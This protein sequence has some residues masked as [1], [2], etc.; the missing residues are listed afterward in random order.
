MS[1]WAE[2]SSVV[3]DASWVSRPA[4]F[5]LKVSVSAWLFLRSAFGTHAEASN[6]NPAM[7]A[8]LLISPPFRP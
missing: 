1:F 7:I 4:D 6:A 2:A 3:R 8:I 5:V